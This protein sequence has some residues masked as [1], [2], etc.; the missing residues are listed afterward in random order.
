MVMG[1]IGGRMARCR[2]VVVCALAWCACWMGCASESEEQGAPHDRGVVVLP[3]AAARFEQLRTGHTVVRVPR[4]GARG[5][6]LHVGD[7]VA[8]RV[9]EPDLPLV[10]AALVLGVDARNLYV[11]VHPAVA[12]CIVAASSSVETLVITLRD[13]GEGSD[14][15]E[16]PAEDDIIP[17]PDRTVRPGRH[18]P[19]ERGDTSRLGNYLK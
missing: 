18:A 12:R 16:V 11:A 1:R 4:E 9:A 17:E 5:S 19:S 15:C 7:Y 6:T 8:L 14:R 13:H 2:A 3:D 10:R